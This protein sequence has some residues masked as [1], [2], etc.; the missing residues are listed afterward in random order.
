MIKPLYKIDHVFR[1]RKGIRNSDLPILYE[2]G[3]FTNEIKN[4]IERD[5]EGKCAV[6]EVVCKDYSKK[7][8]EAYLYYVIDMASK[9][10][11]VERKFF[12]SFLSVFL[13]SRL[14]VLGAS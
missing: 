3:T 11:I 10:N 6:L 7:N 14:L 1:E 8:E 4:R 13:Q 5:P 2:D 12:K 9:Q